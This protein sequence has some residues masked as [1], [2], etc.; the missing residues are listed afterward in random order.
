MDILGK[1]WLPATS[2]FN[3]LLKDPLLD[4]LEEHSL[5]FSR[6][7]PE[8]KTK[9]QRSEFDFQGHMLEQGRDF[10]NKVV[11]VLREVYGEDKV[12]SVHSELGPRDARNA[13]RTLELMQKGIPII[14]SGLVYN[15][16]DKTFGIPDL[17]VR[18][19]YLNKITKT[20]AL[21]KILETKKAKKL[22]GRWHYRILDIKFKCLG[23]RADCKHLLNEGATLAYKGQ[24]FVLNEAL[25]YLQGYTPGAAYLL[26]RQWKCGA[27]FGHSCLD[28][29]G[30]V[31]FK[32]VDSAVPALTRAALSWLRKVKSKEASNWNLLQYPLE[33]PNLY[34]NM[35]NSY[36]Y[37]WKEFKQI[38]AKTTGEL[39]SL[40][41]TGEKNRRLALENGFSSLKQKGLTASVLGFKEGN[42]S[43]T[44]N[45]MIKVTRGREKLLP[46][47]ITNNYEKWKTKLSVEF[48][49]DFETYNGVVSEIKDPL[50]PN[51]ENLIFMIGLGYETEGKWHFKQF[52][53]DDLSLE[54]EGKL[55]S[56][57]TAFV[58]QVSFSKGCLSPR[59]VHWSRAEPLTWTKTL[60]KHPEVKTFSPK[61]L[62]LLTVFKEEP[63]TVKGALSFSLKDVAAAM[64]K[65]GMITSSF[66]GPCAQGLD[67][68]VGARWAHLQARK[69]GTK[70][71]EIQAM[72]EI[73][74]YNKVDV[75]V[76]F[77]ML[78]YLRKN[79]LKRKREH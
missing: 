53:S 45:Q 15:R 7:H 31:N 42:I 17:L 22:R 73:A 58:K 77:E 40:W 16:K 23:F 44:V 66:S 67:A 4:W 30:I 78:N 52:I 57:F 2:T 18:S 54:S 64:K 35:K 46:R 24:L 13:T 39:T 69:N 11:Q 28:R 62:D 19:D 25:G 8:F 72:K 26:G 36:D 43:D 76:L 27:E 75:T 65:Q 14:H 37:K 49:V 21:S 10:E 51:C 34:P 1:D 47:V 29:L 12:I 70:M 74:E 68:L 63:V 3:Y 41:M 79:H 56:E 59:C 33:E 9:H 55:C 6:N 5:K 20:P 38:L 60:L 71:C 32:T 48:F 50:Q 61:W